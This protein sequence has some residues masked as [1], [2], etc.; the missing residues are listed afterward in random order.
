MLPIIEI[1]AF[2]TLQV[3]R[4]NL[5]VTESDWHTRQAR[6]LLKILIT[7]RPRPVSTDRLIEILW[8]TSTPSAAATTLRSAINAL[9]NVLEPDRIS[10]APSRYIATQTPGY[11]FNLHQDIWLDVD[12][13]ERA[14][15]QAHRSSDAEERRQLLED[16]VGLYKDDY[17]ISDPYADRVQ[18]ERERLRERYF[19]ALLAL[20]EIQ[21]ASNDFAEAI[22][23]CRRILARDEVRENAYQL[24]M[25]CQA[26]SGDSASAL[27]TYERC[28]TILAEELA[29]IPARLRNSYTNAYST[30]RSIPSATVRCSIS[31]TSPAAAASTTARPRPHCRSQDPSRVRSRCPRA[32]CCRHWTNDLSR[33]LSDASKKLPRWNDC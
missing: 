25:R 26:E 18:N 11:A 33:S 13:F 16:A 20:S 6:Q 22:S 9:R 17:L 8:P 2:G 1:R 3:V 23:A 32:C 4:D 29:P 19:N 21:A 30:A 14:L 27:L 24:L 5:S 15:D 31:P 10:R 12:I 28:R 7:E